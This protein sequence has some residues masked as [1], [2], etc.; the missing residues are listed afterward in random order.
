MSWS[1]KCLSYKHNEFEPL[2]SKA[3]VAGTCNPGARDAEPG[4]SLGLLSRSL[5]ESATYMLGKSPCF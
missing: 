4:G 3:D 5:A 1:L 2:T